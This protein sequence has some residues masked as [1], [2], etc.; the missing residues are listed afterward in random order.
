MP[1]LLGRY[2]GLRSNELLQSPNTDSLRHLDDLVN[3]GVIDGLIT[4]Q[5]AQELESI[6]I[7]V[8]AEDGDNKTVYVVVEASII[9]VD[10]HDVNRALERA[11]VLGGVTNAPVRAAVVGQDIS[12]AQPRAGRRAR[13]HVHAPL[14]RCPAGPP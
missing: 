6:D 5:Q 1:R 4:D 2:L 13:S 3:Q 10:D 12:T 8:I 11:T 7:F 9:I 14:I